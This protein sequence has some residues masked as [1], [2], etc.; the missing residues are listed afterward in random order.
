[1]GSSAW[2]ISGSRDDKHRRRSDS[3]QV[4]GFCHAL[5]VQRSKSLIDHRGGQP[6]WFT[7]TLARRALAANARAK[8]PFLHFDVD[9]VVLELI[10]SELIALEL[11]A[12]GYEWSSSED[13]EGGFVAML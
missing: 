3:E 13:V 8:N 12:S 5:I 11:V 10:A 2:D 4:F 6:R 1:M 9:T 7:F